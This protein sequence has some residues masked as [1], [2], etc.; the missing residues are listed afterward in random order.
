MNYYWILLNTL[1]QNVHLRHKIIQLLF[2]LWIIDSNF[3]NNNNNNNKFIKKNNLIKSIFTLFIDMKLPEDFF[4]DDYDN[5]LNNFCI[6][7]NKEMKKLFL[8]TYFNK[9]GEFILIDEENNKNNNNNN[10]IFT[11]TKNCNNIITELNSI[12]NYIYK[13]DLKENVLNSLINTMLMNSNKIYF[14]IN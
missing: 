14:K 7:F 8:N 4:F 13:S 12:H 11:I 6:D 3:L 10:E 1:I 9:N 5:F 2:T